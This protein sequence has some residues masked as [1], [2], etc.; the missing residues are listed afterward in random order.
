RPGL[1]DGSTWTSTVFSG[2]CCATEALQTIIATAQITIPRRK[3]ALKRDRRNA[4]IIS[5]CG[6][7]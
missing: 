3:T 4:D 2:P 6:R 1:T 7:S 5:Y